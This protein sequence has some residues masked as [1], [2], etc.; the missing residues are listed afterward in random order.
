[1]WLG[2]ALLRM[3]QIM[4]LQCSMCSPGAYQPKVLPNY[5][6]FGHHCRLEKFPVGRKCIY[7]F[8]PVLS[9]LKEFPLR[10]IHRWSL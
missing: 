1:M 8:L 7:L 5:G 3:H 10:S 6:T 2:K 4:W 9:A